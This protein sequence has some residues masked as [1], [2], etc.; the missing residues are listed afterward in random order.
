MANQTKKDK[1]T[2]YT[3]KD[4]EGRWYIESANGK[5][6]NDTH[7][8]TYGEAID[9]LAEFEDTDISKLKETINFLSE[10]VKANAQQ[11]LNVAVEEIE[12]AEKS[13]LAKIFD[14]VDAIIE[15][16]IYVDV[17][18]D[19]ETRCEEHVCNSEAIIRAIAEFKEKLLWG[20]QEPKTYI[21]NTTESEL[22]KYN[23]TEV[24]IIRSLTPEE[25]DTEDVGNMYEIRFYDGYVR[26]AFEDELTPVG[27][28]VNVS[29]EASSKKSGYICSA[30]GDPKLKEKV[31]AMHKLSR[32]ILNDSGDI[33]DYTDDE[34]RVLDMVADFAVAYDTAFPQRLKNPPT[35]DLLPCPFCGT[36]NVVLE[37]Y[38]ARKGYE[39]YVQCNGG[40]MAMQHTITYDTLEKAESEARRLWNARASFQKEDVV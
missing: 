9:R 17:F 23:G 25:C 14:G 10:T 28:N 8:R 24:E 22:A 12:E 11:A 19:G 38:K 29:A 3:Q 33:G 2:R 6:E 4:K 20:S 16:H 39:A 36:D 18:D 15:R 30:F 1:T 32:E 27:K 26:Y 21:F 40:C 34:E 5:L 13:I 35:S 37:S 31:D 7:G